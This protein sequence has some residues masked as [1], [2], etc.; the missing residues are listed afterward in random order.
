MTARKVIKE[1]PDRLA[2]VW[3]GTLK[4]PMADLIQGAMKGLLQYHSAV[5]HAAVH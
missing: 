2:G 3:N 5:S 4:L 1:R